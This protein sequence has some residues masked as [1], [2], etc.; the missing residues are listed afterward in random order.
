MASN[1]NT[2]NKPA[3]VL[4]SD[5]PTHTLIREREKYE[6]QFAKEKITDI[7]LRSLDTVEESESR[8]DLSQTENGEE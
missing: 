3:E 6:D 5:G 8:E 7:S 2:R 1:Y 4:V